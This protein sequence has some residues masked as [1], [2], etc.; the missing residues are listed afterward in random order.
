MANRDSGNSLLSSRLSGRQQKPSQQVPDVNALRQHM[1]SSSDI[2]AY[3]MD[4]N[5]GKGK[6]TRKEKQKPKPA[7]ESPLNR[8]SSNRNSGQAASANGH[9]RQKT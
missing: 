4:S 3:E 8:V 2:P 5:E 9:S 6:K 7:S 1:S